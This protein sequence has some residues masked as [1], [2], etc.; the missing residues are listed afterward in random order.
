MIN[1]ALTHDLL[2]QVT[3]A[4]LNAGVA[5]GAQYAALYRT[6]DFVEGRRAEAEGRPP[7]YT[8]R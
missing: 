8:G 2:P 5:A 6:E 4:A 3:L 7:N 1:I